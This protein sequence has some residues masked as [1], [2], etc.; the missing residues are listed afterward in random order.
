MKNLLLLIGDKIVVVRYVILISS[1]LI[2]RCAL[3]KKL[4]ILETAQEV[5]Q[6]FATDTMQFKR[7]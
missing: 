5:R 1:N 6:L 2:E 7:P 3:G 4:K